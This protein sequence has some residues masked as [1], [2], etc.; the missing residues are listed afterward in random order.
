MFRFSKAALIA[1]LA[2]SL[3]VLLADRAGA[4][5]GGIFGNAPPRPPGAITSPDGAEIQQ[6]P[7]DEDVPDLP[8]G[9]VLPTPQRL[10]P[11]QSTRPGAPPPSGV[12]SQPLPPPPG[13][14]AAP[15]QSGAPT[16]TAPST[17]PGQPPLAG[18]PPG[19]RQPRGTPGA[20]PPPA[21]V[22]PGDEIVTEPPT[23]KITNKAAVFSG[24]DKVTGRIIK[25]D[26]EIGET[27]QF[28]ALRVT[29]RVCYTRPPTE[30]ANTDAFI[31][32]EEITLQGEVKKLF[33]GWMFAASPGLNAVEH[34][35]Y[36]V[37]LSDCKGP[38]TTAVA[39]T[40]Q[41]EPVK[42]AAPRPA[43]Q[44]PQKRQPSAQQRLPALPTPFPSNR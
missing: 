40:Q 7:D 37:W 17:P 5:F 33:S 43:A 4:Q 27:V 18:L 24:L 3:A 44:P 2:A 29:P 30:A 9:R 1:A 11:P 22:Q 21:T 14:A 26:A 19:Q 42:P 6:E 8:Q 32:V 34:P 16:A 36:D 39:N 28:G 12:Q 31:E 35:I 10:P 23:V 20:P 15:P 41:V 38:D 13:A 25:F